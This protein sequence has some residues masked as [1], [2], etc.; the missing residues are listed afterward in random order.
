[1]KEGALLEEE[2]VRGNCEAEEEEEEWVCEGEEVVDDWEMMLGRKCW[3]QE[4]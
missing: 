4:E 1:M 2:E 3:A